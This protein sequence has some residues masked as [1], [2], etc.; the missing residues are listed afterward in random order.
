MSQDRATP[1][2]AVLGSSGGNLR[3]HG[4][5]DPA[6]LLGDVRR[7]IEAAGW[8]LGAVQ[9]VAADSPVA[10]SSARLAS[11]KIR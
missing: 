11:V 6:R 1:S 3:S 7:Q 8:E 9:F 5:D 2:I 4:G 10:M